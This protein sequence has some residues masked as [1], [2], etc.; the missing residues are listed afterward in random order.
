MKKS[1]ALLILIITIYGHVYAQSIVSNSNSKSGILV[2]S[3]TDFAGIGYKNESKGFSFNYKFNKQDN[4]KKEGRKYPDFWG[5]NIGSGIK[6]DKSKTNLISNGKWNGG[7]DF[8]LTLFRTLDKTKEGKKIEESNGISH[9]EI[10]KIKQNT[11]YINIGDAFER[12]N[13]LQHT[14]I[15]EDTTFVAFSSPMQNVLTITPGYYSLS[16]W[17]SKLFFSWALSANIKFNNNS[18]TKLSKTNILLLYNVVLNAK[19]STIIHQVGTQKSYYSGK[20][21]PEISVIPRA[22][23]FLRYSIGSKKPVIG[24]LAA[25]S[26]VISTMEDVKSRNNFAI[27]PTFGL[28]S[29]PDQVLFSIMNQF[30]QDKTGGYNFSLIFQATV[31]IKFE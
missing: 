16:Q 31:P 29:F 6:T 9:S 17:K 2:G 10:S 21:G 1:R 15:N 26:P 14:E 25:Y 22:D 5:L 3:T 13:T 12:I 8:D 27:G 18:I 11:W 30:N 4:T 23:I 20:T 19:D 7:V 24:L 28:D